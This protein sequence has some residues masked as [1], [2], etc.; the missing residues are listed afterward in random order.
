[1]DAYIHWLQL[2][3]L[4]QSGVDAAIRKLAEAVEFFVSNVN[5]SLLVQ[6]NGIIDAKAIESWNVDEH[7]GMIDAKARILITSCIGLSI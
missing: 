1:M 2:M 7:D 3:S 5:W 6:R 4:N